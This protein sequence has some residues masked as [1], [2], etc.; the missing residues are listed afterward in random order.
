MATSQCGGTAYPGYCPGAANIQCC[1]GGGA[2]ATPCTVPGRGAGSCLSTSQCGGTP[3][4]GYCPGAG[5]V[6]CCVAGA[7]PRLTTGPGRVA[8]RGAAVKP[9][10]VAAVSSVPGNHW[11]GTV[12]SNSQREMAV[13]VPSNV[14]VS[15]PVE[16]VYYFHG[17][18]GTIANGLADPYAGFNTEIRRVDAAGRNRVYVIPQ[19]PPKHLDYTWMNS[20]ESITALQAEAEA[21]L[22]ALAP[23]GLRIGKITVKGHSAGGRAL[24]NASAAGLRAD[25]MDFLDGSYGAWASTAWRNQVKRNPQLDTHVVYIPGTATQANALSLQGAAGVTLHKSAVNHALVPKTFLAD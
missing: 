11:V 4:P 15:K 19:G 17:H 5:N 9:E 7:A 24:M 23:A 20:G 1:I 10:T 21:R 8:T 3:Y 14:S 12:D 22:R 6:Q 25:R 18:R 13:M 2:A 16:V